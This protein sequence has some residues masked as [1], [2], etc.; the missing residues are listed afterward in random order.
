MQNGPDR[1]ITRAG[2]PEASKTSDA[3]HTTQGCSD[4]NSVFKETVRQDSRVRFFL[5]ICLVSNKVQTKFVKTDDT[6]HEL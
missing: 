1:E 6:R 5:F 2:L 3:V 4:F